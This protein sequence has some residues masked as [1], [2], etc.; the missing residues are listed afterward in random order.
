MKPGINTQDS[1]YTSD[2]LH[3][4]S[5]EEQTNF[6]NVHNNI[7]NNTHLNTNLNNNNKTNNTNIFHTHNIQ[8][9]P[10]RLDNLKFGKFHLIIIL[11]LGTTWILDGYE[12]SLL[13]V[14]SGVI[15]QMYNMNDTEIGAAGS[16]YL[17]GAVTGA[18]FFGYLASKLGR[19]ML[20][21]I[22]LIIYIISIV[23]TSAAINKYM[24]YGCR[25]ATGLAVGGEYSAIFAAIDEL[26]PPY[27]RGRADLIID[28]T[29]HFGSCLASISGYV[30]LTYISS[31][32]NS[33]IAV[34]CLFVIGAILACCIIYLRK[35]VPE[36]PRWLLYKGRIHEAV[37]IV[38]EIEAQCV[39]RKK[40]PTNKNN[41][42]S[43]DNTLD[44]KFN[45]LNEEGNKD[46]NTTNTAYNPNNPNTTPIKNLE[47]KEIT[48]KKI[49]NVLFR[50]H[51]KRFFYAASLMAS[52]AFFYNGVFYT[53]TLILQ[54]FE[55]ISKETVGLYLIPLSVASF[56]G[57]LFIGPFFDSWSRRKM[58]LLTYLSTFVLL[59]ITAFNFLFGYFNFFIQQCLWFITFFIASPGASSAHL[60]VSEIF[61]LEMRS[62]ALAIFFSIGYGVGGIVAPLLMGALV[63][64]NDKTSIFY[65]YIISAIIMALGGIIGF[66]FGIDAERKSLEDIA[67]NMLDDEETNVN[68]SNNNANNTSGN[69]ENKTRKD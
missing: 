26:L 19:K 52:Q 69:N 59:T 11:A 24:F 16:V 61:P 20:F 56:T 29:W 36:S 53:Y 60:T 7:N 17:S 10:R 39:I 25:F 5:S 34:R 22:T 31:D 40:E 44:S 48:I 47:R 68:N 30:T 46:D 23:A 1:S 43:K 8:N 9:I 18:L 14:L 58:I 4:S 6:L 35:N 41:Q 38:N 55:N 45:L 32:S 50:V 12:V 27:V 65:A 3:Y 42:Y 2:S 57:P 63:N 13:S 49:C 15:K 67:G 66:T 37:K 21:S 54:K 62:Q 28:G 33:Y 64:E 51:P